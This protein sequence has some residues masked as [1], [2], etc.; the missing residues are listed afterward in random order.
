LIE[1]EHTSSNSAAFDSSD[2][3]RLGGIVNKPDLPEIKGC[4]DG[5]CNFGH[6]GGMH[7]NGGC[8]CLKNPQSERIRIH[9][10]I[11]ELRNEI[12]R[13]EV[14]RSQRIRR[15]NGIRFLARGTGRYLPLRQFPGES[16]GI[17]GRGEVHRESGC[18]LAC[19]L[20]RI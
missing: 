18:Q 10:N 1:L 16:V 11:V 5:G 13:V 2:M 4:T 20:P 17:P 8:A 9:R 6:P 7:T 3:R 19:A 12:S 15:P 14:Q